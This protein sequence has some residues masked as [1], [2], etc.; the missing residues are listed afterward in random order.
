MHELFLSVICLGFIY[1][2]IRSILQGIYPPT[3]KE[4]PDFYHWEVDEQDSFTGSHVLAEGIMSPYNARLTSIL[5]GS[6]L[7][8]LGLGILLYHFHLPPF[9]RDNF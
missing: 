8:L 2:G 1:Q 5:V 4:D 7:I 6:F 3:P 9:A